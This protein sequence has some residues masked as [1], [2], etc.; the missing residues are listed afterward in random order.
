MADRLREMKG[1]M[2]YEAFGAL[3]GVSAQ[4]VQK[5]M[6]GGNV[7]DEKLER[8]IASEPFRNRGFTVE[9]VRYGN[10]SVARQSYAKYLYPRA[11]ENVT[12]GLG[13]GR[14][15]DEHEVEVEGRVAVPSSLIAARGWNIDRL[16]VVETDGMSMFPTLNDN[17]PV[18]VNLEEV[19]IVN[20]K[21]Y[22]IEDD[23]EGL[24][25]KRLTKQRDGR[26]L[27]RSD[28][29]DKLSFPDDY[30]TPDTRTRIVGRVCYRSGEL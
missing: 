8:L 26:V 28:N 20:G 29:P 12:A 15:N 18:V 16:R 22:A 19:K 9:W 1:A 21:V 2:S 6:T 23:D 30:L 4:A 17:E 25:I 3:A 10:R 11:Y 5:W 14:F 7:T 13:R 27:V 24:R